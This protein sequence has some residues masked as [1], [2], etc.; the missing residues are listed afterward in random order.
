MVSH[1]ASVEPDDGVRLRGCIVHQYLCFL[2]GVG[3]GRRFLGANSVEHYKHGGVNSARDV[4]KG[5]I[6][7]L[8]AHDVAF[9]KFWCGSGVGRV[10]HLIP[11][12]RCEPFV[13]RVLKARAY[14]VLEALRGF[15]DVVGHRDIDVVS[16]VF[17]IGGNSVVIAA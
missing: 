10:L 17:S 4:E 5:A 11:I 13:G 6:N 16:R 3:S 12:H 9:L 7:A 15:S 1:V 8:Y 2:D 14:G